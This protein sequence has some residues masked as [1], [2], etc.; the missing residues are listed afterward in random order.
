MEHFEHRRL[1]HLTQIQDRIDRT[2]GHHQQQKLDIALRLV[3]V[4]A[5]SVA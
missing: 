2:G 3:L 1:I 5:L 4:Q